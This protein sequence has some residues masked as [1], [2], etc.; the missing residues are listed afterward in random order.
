MEPLFVQKTVWIILPALNP[1]PPAASCLVASESWHSIDRSFASWW[2]QGTRLKGSNLLFACQNKA[3]PNPYKPAMANRLSGWWQQSCNIKKTTQARALLPS[4]IWR[5]QGRNKIR[6]SSVHVLI[7]LALRIHFQLSN[8]T[9][10]T[11]PPT[12][13]LP[14]GLNLEY[15]SLNS[16]SVKVV[17]GCL[18]Q[19]LSPQ[20]WTL[21]KQ[22]KPN[23]RISQRS[24]MFLCRALSALDFIPTTRNVLIC[25]MRN[26]SK[27][28]SLLVCEYP[29]AWCL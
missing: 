1:R 12:L 9:D 29:F 22:S 5:I 13:A 10:S 14:T 26:Q 24:E 6:F 19:S 20:N 27:S 16:L 8:S 17:T 15:L 23:R 28:K 2:W 4:T 11:T 18:Q 7:D 25:G 21:E 3:Q